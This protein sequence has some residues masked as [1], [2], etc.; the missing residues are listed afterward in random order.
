MNMDRLKIK[1]DLLKEIVKAMDQGLTLGDLKKLLS[2]RLQLIAL[3]TD[4]SK[5]SPF[6]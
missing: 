1:A 6:L 2:A 3:G 4:S 5:L